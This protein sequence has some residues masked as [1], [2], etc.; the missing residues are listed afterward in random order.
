[1]INFGLQT[2]LS[3][4][5]VLRNGPQNYCIKGCGNMYSKYAWAP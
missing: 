5:I 1:M 2:D 4:K 3:Y